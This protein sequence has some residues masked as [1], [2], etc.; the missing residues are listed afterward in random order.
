MPDYHVTLVP[1]GTRSVIVHA[2]TPELAPR[3]AVD[4]AD[5]QWGTDCY[6]VPTDV[7]LATEEDFADDHHPRS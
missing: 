5:Q 6:W 4:L 3:V 7:R 1:S 2:E